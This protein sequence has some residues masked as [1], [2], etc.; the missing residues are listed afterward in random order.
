MKKILLSA[1]AAAAVIP[2]MH[3][4]VTLNLPTDKGMPNDINIERTLISDWAGAVTKAQ[5]RT[6]RYEVPVRGS[7]VTFDLDTMGAAYYKVSLIPD[8]SLDFFAAPDENI[9]F[10]IKSLNPLDYTAEGSELLSGMQEINKLTEPVNRRYEELITTD[11]ADEESVSALMNEYNDI[12]RNYIESNP[13]A[14][15]IP[16]LIMDMNG[17]DFLAAYDNLSEKARQSMLMPLLDREKSG[18]EKRLE[19]QRMQQR[20]SEGHVDAPLF[21]LK[22]TEGKDVSLSDFRGK[23]VILDFWGTWCPWC[24]KGFPKLKEAYTQYGDRLEIIGIDC[25]D[26]ENTWK[27]GVKRYEL[28]WVNVYNP[29]SNSALLEQYGVQGFPTKVIINPEGKI[30]DIIT[31]EDPTFYTK[32]ATLIKH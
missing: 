13:D 26:S 23:W 7:K 25:R 30:A 29:D 27:D 11:K 20:M 6:V 31:G 17:E 16:L 19:Q 8:V 18:I 1:I 4:D 9:T 12:I 10:N 14:A 21:T 5:R 28:P 2:A 32:L 22:D 15:V 3:A 24:I